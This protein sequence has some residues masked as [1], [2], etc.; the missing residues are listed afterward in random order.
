[1]EKFWTVIAVLPEGKIIACTRRGKQHTLRA[2]D[3]A[4]RPARWWERILFA[5]RFPGPAQVGVPVQSANAIAPDLRPSPPITPGD[6]AAAE[7]PIAL[8]IEQQAALPW[9]G[10]RQPTVDAGRGESTLAVG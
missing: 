7:S 6:P 10:W 8:P 2:D 9:F 3:P 5:K 1:V 4:L